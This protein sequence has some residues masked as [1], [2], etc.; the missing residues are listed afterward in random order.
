MA[1]ESA[2]VE[3]ALRAAVK[4]LDGKRLSREEKRDLAWWEKHQRE[5]LQAEILRALPK[6]V[7]CQLAGRQQK[8]ID[9]QARQYGLPLIGRELD[10]GAAIKALHDLVAR[11]A[12]N[13][14]PEGGPNLGETKLSEQVK[15]QRLRRRLI[16]L[17]IEVKRDAYIK[18][19]ELRKRLE[20]WAE[21]LR[22]FGGQLGRKFGREAQQLFNDFLAGLA[23]T[24]E[25]QD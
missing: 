10:L 23:L 5:Q 16:A 9:E 6:G 22:I 20:W 8:V 18:R 25:K 15:T 17:E 24:V 4:R 14:R 7:Y 19:E 3:S 13:I 11:N 12:A 21:Q 2:R 1:S